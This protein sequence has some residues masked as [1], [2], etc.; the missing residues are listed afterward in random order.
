MRK[1]RPKT[2]MEQFSEREL[3][4]LVQEATVDCHDEDEQ[5]LGLFTMIED[6]LELPFETTVLGVP[7]R[8]ERIELTDRSDIVAVCVRDNETQAIPLSRLPLPS[9]PPPGAQWIA[10][11]RIWA[12]GQS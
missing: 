10:A 4:E 12:S 7:V 3:R 11:Y 9:P 5:V 2:F 6:H 1:N 8:V